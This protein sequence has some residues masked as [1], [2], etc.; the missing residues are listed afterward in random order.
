MKRVLNQDAAPLPENPAQYLLSK[1]IFRCSGCIENTEVQ[2][3]GYDHKVPPADDWGTVNVQSAS[4]TCRLQREKSRC[5]SF[6][7]TS[8]PI[9]RPSTFNNHGSANLPRLSRFIP[10][11]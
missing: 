8:N 7:R 1:G 3:D 2:A 9:R 10:S 4:R 11:P 6:S 5:T